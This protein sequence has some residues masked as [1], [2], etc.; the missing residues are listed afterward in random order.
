MGQDSAFSSRSLHNE[1]QFLLI[2]CLLLP[3]TQSVEH[4]MDVWDSEG[5]Y[6]L[7]IN[8]WG[9]AWMQWQGVG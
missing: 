7:P 5:M 8:S 3:V 2:R 1:A 9:F 4:R 6:A